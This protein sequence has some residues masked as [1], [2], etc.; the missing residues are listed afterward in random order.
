MTAVVN[1][2]KDPYLSGVYTPVT[3]ERDDSG[4]AVTGAL[5]AG[6]AGTYLR[7]GPNPVFEPKGRY[8]I[9]DGDGMLHGLTLDGE[10]GAAYRN[11]WVR[12]EGLAVE[13]R[14]GRAIY[15]GMANGEFPSREETG[16]G[17][18][19]KNVANTN[20]IRHAGRILA[21][22][23][24]GA[25]TEVSPALD[26]I[27]LHDFGGALPGPFTAH[28]KLDPVTGEMLAFGY[29]AVPPYLRAYVIGPDGDFRRTIDIDLPAPVMMHDFAITERHLVFLDAPAVFDFASFAAGGPMLTWKPENGTRIG[30][31][32]RDGDG[33]SV[34]WHDVD[35]CYVFHFMNAFDTPAGGVVV[36]ACRLPRMDIGLESEGTTADAN[37]WLHRFTVEPGSG[38]TRCEQVAELPGDFPRVPAALEGRPYRYGYYAS[39]SSGRP[40]GGSFDSVTKVDHAAGTTATHTYGDGVVAGEAV[41][42]ADPA[43]SGEDDGW[44]LNFVTDLPTL[45]SAFVV[46][47][48]R[49]LTEVARI[50]MPRHVPAGFHG[51][52]LPAGGR[53]H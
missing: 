27:G 20:V 37:S 28:P 41:F 11:R 35:P 44:L 51:N 39:F 50:A 12:T 18:V 36:D 9:F 10:G 14:A 15:G 3:D 46:L 25:P 2:R 40:A 53:A 42:A 19:M 48:A 45:T 31:M 1:S 33:A 26:T 5:P 24:A 13:R 23:E 43:R 52:W 38:S 34:R 7:N 30:V 4:L 32:P 16:G 6:L 49:D 22:W 29:S 47:D 8:H 21:L 17:P